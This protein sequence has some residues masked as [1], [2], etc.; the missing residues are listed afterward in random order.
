MFDRKKILV[1]P[2]DGIGRD[3]CQSAL[4]L[5]D[6][7]DL[8]LD[9][10]FGDIGWEFWK[11]SG[12]PVP[13]H[14][15]DQIANSDSVLLGAITS[16]PPAEAEA[17]LAEDLRGRGLN[18]KSPVLQLRHKLDL[19]A[20]VRSAYYMTGPQK[21]FRFDV[22]R[23]N[24]EGLYAGLDFVGIPVAMREV[25]QHQNIKRCGPNE[26]AITLRLQTRFGLERLYRFAFEHARKSGFGK[27]TLADKPNVMRASSAFLR[28]IFQ[29]IAADFPDI[30]PEIHNVDA[31]AMWMVTRPERFGVV[32]AENMFGDILSDLAGGVMGGLGLAASANIGTHGAYYE[33]VHGSAPALEGQDR[34]NPAAMILTMSTMLR[35]M[36]YSDPADRLS[37]A[38]KTV[39]RK[40]RNLTYDFGGT[41]STVQMAQTVR[42]ATKLTQ[43]SPHAAILTIGDELL[44]GRF[45]NTNL[46]DFS[47]R[48]VTKGMTVR[49][50]QVVGD[51]MPDISGALK[52]YVGAREL[53]LIS[54]G[55]GPTSDDVTRQSVA[56]FCG[57]DLVENAD[58]IA[59]LEQ[60]YADL[61][62]P[63]RAVDRCQALLPKGAVPL[64][65]P[66]G[67][68]MG[69]AIVKGRSTIVVLPGPPKEALPMLD[70]FLADFAEK[71]AAPHWMVFNQIETD[72]APKVD[73][74]LSEFK[75]SG[76]Y[77]WRFPYLEVSIAPGLENVVPPPAI[78]AVDALLSAD[79][80]DRKGRTA[81][82]ALGESQIAEIACSDPALAE[83]IAPLV[84]PNGGPIALELRA[85][86]QFSDVL[87]GPNLGEVKLC[88]S[89]N[90]GSQKETSLVLRG[91]NLEMIVREFVCWCT[92]SA[93]PSEMKTT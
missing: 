65:N 84:N 39:I 83:M 24:T 64:A 21:P 45:A 85:D 5:L 20:N 63:V 75:L 40:S 52:E 28:D 6:E 59:H 60:F 4:P 89:F 93:T 29:S 23:E 34:A 44:E 76:R 54:G 27:V 3:V 91:Q 13:A 55:I 71:Q 88:C 56:A 72:I 41:L 2:G 92:L 77:L 62:L 57:C 7:F 16:K 1:L 11:S 61:Q 35:D 33:P 58:A 18:Y 66:V 12:D 10:Q 49:N 17:E 69:F 87:N 37:D 86:R 78:D 81:S 90:G 30:E 74:V 42:D 26:S 36:G 43:S 70:A 38:V 67:A 25:V 8:P 15:W 50:Q 22:I 14:T 51:R 68:A 79:V 31:I 80:V 47:R 9:V 46:L 19:F 32:V 53:I 82:Q 73:A 48:L